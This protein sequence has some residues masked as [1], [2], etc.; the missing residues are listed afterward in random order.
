MSLTELH[1]CAT[2]DLD[3]SELTTIHIIWNLFNHIRFSAS[4][5]PYFS[6]CSFLAF[7]IKIVIAACIQIE[8]KQVYTQLH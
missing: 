1:G 2:V 8:Y 6:T 5:I 3:V 7:F 4:F